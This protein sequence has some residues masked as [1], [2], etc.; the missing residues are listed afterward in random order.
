MISGVISLYDEDRNLIEKQIKDYYSKTVRYQY[1]E[2]NRCIS[3][4]LFDSNGMLMRK[5]LF[6]F[7]EDGNVVAEQT[8]EMD[9]TRGGRDKHFS[10]RYEYEYY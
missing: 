6:E 9:T 2:H 10:S 1:D 7:D 8:Y 5:N 4:E 3:N